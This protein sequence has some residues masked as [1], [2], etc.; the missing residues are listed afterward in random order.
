M[1]KTIQ[2]LVIIVAI[3]TCAKLN[4]QTCTANAGN[5]QTICCPGGQVTLGGSPSSNNNCQGVGGTIQYSWKPT[6]G[7]SNP[8]IA[9]PIASPNTTTTYTLCAV[10]YESTST[11]C[12]LI[13]CV[14]CDVVVVTVNGGCC[15]LL[16]PGKTAI[17]QYASDI[18]LY[19]NPASADLTIDVGVDLKNAEI[20]MYD[21]TGRIIWQKKNI[22]NKIKYTVDISTF[23]KG[24][25]FV[26][27]IIEGSEVY[28]NKVLIE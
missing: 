13:C 6:T 4:A 14:A 5:D 9:N 12:T 10:A 2:L 26:K 27:A 3:F 19:P 18:N 7:L 20:N 23:P 1:K 28:N 21:I 17:G 11:T 16:A 24:V 8:T 15:R 25:Y 22:T